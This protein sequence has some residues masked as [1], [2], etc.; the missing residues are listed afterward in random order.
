MSFTLGKDLGI[1]MAKG[2]IFGVAGCITVLPSLI[3]LFDKLLSKAHHR[4]LI[5]D[6]KK[7]SGVIIK[8]FPVWKYTITYLKVFLTIWI[9]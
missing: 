2:V 8:I 3:L 7:A 1:V 4:S 9:M 5:P 6:M